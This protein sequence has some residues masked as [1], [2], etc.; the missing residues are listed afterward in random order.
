MG[1]LS[2][3]EW[4]VLCFFAAVVLM[5]FYLIRK[6]ELDGLFRDLTGPRWRQGWTRITLLVLALFCFLGSWRTESFFAPAWRPIGIAAAIIFF[7]AGAIGP[8]LLQSRRYKQWRKQR[9]RMRSAN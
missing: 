8:E 1:R 2:A 9:D 5:F 4:L 7:M 6:K 3:G